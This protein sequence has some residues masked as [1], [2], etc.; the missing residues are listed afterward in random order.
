MKAITIPLVLALSLGALAMVGCTIDD[1]DRCPEGFQFEKITLSC[2]PIPQESEGDSSGGEDTG[3]DKDT[4]DA[5]DGPSGLGEPCAG[6]PGACAA[7]GY[8]ADYCVVNPLEQDKAYC[9]SRDCTADSCEK[10]YRCCDC[11]NSM[12]LPKLSACL[13]D[14]DADLAGSAAGGC[15]C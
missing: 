2:H 14:A 7:A 9:S 8:E 12:V 13:K 6:D 1:E 10:G 3:K 15:Q 5:G 4:N 11:T